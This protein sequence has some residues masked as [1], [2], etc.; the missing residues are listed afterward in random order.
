MEPTFFSTIHKKSFTPLS[1]IWKLENTYRHVHIVQLLIK[2][3]L[4]RRNTHK[5]NRTAKHLLLLCLI[6]IKKERK[7]Y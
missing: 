2:N 5:K 6:K 7:Y 4:V 1:N 3:G